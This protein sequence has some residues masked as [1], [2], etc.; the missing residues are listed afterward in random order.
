MSY[1]NELAEEI[2]INDMIAYHQQVQR[3]SEGIWIKRDGTNVNIHDMTVAHIYNC[4]NMLSGRTDD[5]S[6][7]WVRR[8]K[9]ELLNR[10]GL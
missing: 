5:I 7:M 4:L 10:K 9:K 8:F 3:I 2:M 6:D 1:G